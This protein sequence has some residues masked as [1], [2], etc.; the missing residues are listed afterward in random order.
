M[1]RQQ[2]ESRQQAEDILWS[3]YDF[4]DKRRIHSGCGYRTPIAVWDEYWSNHTRNCRDNDR[5]TVA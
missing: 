3:W 2:F 5:A 4:Y 1:T